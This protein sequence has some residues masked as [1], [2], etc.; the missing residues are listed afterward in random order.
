[1]CEQNK[2]RSGSTLCA[3]WFVMLFLTEAIYS[4]Y[5]R[6]I[7]QWNMLPIAVIW[8]SHI[9]RYQNNCYCACY[10]LIHPY[11]NP[12]LMYKVLPC[13]CKRI[14]LMSTMNKTDCINTLCIFKPTPAGN[15]RYRGRAVLR[16]SVYDGHM[17]EDLDLHCSCMQ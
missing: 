5:P 14:I 12:Q 9:T 15:L 10:H 7:S 4:F 16:R 6:T 8:S 11:L 3:F 13:T 17:P 1:M 2:S